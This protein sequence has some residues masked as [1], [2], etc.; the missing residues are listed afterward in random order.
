MAGI[1]Y[2][3]LLAAD[4]DGVVTIDDD[5]GYQVGGRYFPPPRSRAE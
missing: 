2:A 1:P 3:D 4:R 5:G